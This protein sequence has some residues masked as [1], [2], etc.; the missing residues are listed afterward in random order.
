MSAK[1][2]GV[3]ARLP[4]YLTVL[5]CQAGDRTAFT[6]LYEQYDDRLRRY[7]AGLGMGDAV[8]DV[9]QEVWVTVFRRIAHLSNP[10][11]FRQW[12][13]RIARSRVFDALRRV[14][15]RDV[16]QTAVALEAAAQEADEI[17]SDASAQ[18]VES[19]M[20][21]LSPHHREVLQLRYFEDL[22]YSEIASVVGCSIG[23]IRSRLHHAKSAPRE[24]LIKLGREARES[25]KEE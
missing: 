24:V 21:E 5:R 9:V 25:G 23:T 8:D 11:A 7:V 10:G 2:V 1:D 19:A 16:L 18:E 14:R 20:A 4:E 12:V 13:Y 3:R 15:R 6:R 17:T 22:P